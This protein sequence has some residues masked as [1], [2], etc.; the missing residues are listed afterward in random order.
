MALIECPQCG[1]KMSDKASS[2]PQCGMPIE[3]IKIALQRV[4]VND[5]GKKD[6]IPIVMNQQS[7]EKKGMPKWVWVLIIVGSLLI[8]GGVV[9]FCFLGESSNPEAVQEEEIAEIT[10]PKITEQGV[11]P[12]IVGASMYDIS[13][14]GD[15]Y[16]TILL[17]KRYNAYMEGLTCG[18]NL[19]EKEL[20]E[21]KR[22]YSW[23]TLE[24]V[25]CGFAYV[26]KDNDTLM[27]IDYDENA[28]IQSITV[29]SEQ[30]KMQNGVCV[31]VSATEMLEKHHALFITPSSYN[32]ELG[33]N[34]LG[35]D[36]TFN[37]PDQSVNISV[38][39]FYDKIDF[40]YKEQ[41]ENR[42]ME[43]MD[44]C[45]YDTLPLEAVKGS[46]VRSIVIH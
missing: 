11:E 29:L 10:Y 22:Q 6:E 44:F 45:A 21:L 25:A 31:G 34:G 32:S 38:K 18:T 3:E 24:V 7:K 20:Q 42:I 12:F 41:Y 15:F 28:I 40:E 13:V 35:D 19:N 14:K 46:S 39:A 5:V 33:E 17:V 8:V 36:A 16:D 43:T 37:L 27:K 1:R 9:F 4:S 30:I 2:C 26:I 23:T